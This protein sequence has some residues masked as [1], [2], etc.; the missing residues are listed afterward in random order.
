MSKML[1]VL[2]LTLIISV[3]SSGQI[4]E[5]LDD[6]PYN[7]QTLNQPIY[8]V[9]VFSLKSNFLN[10]SIFFNNATFDVDKFG[11]DSQQFPGWPMITD[12]VFF[13]DLPIVVDIDHDGEDEVVSLGYRIDRHNDIPRNYI[14]LID[15]DGSIMPGFPIRITDA[16]SLNVAD[17]DGD[18]EY[19]IMTYSVSEKRLRCFDRFGYT[20]PGWPIEIPNDLIGHAPFGSGGAVGDL[21]MDGTNEYIL[22]GLFHIYA[23][24]FDGSMQPGFPIAIFDRTFGFSN[25]W[26]WPPVLVDIDLDGFLEIVTTA[27]NWIDNYPPQLISFVAIYEHDSSMKT[28]WPVYFYDDILQHAPTPGD[29]DND[30]TIEIGIQGMQLNFLDINGNQLPGWPITLYKPGGGTWGCRS[31]LIIVDIDGDGDC[32]IFTDYST[33]YW[34]TTTWNGYSYFFGFNHSGN[35]L[36]G[37]PFLVEGVYHVRPPSFGYDQNTQ[38]LYMGLF[39]EFVWPPQGIDSAYIEIYQFPD[40]TGP[41]DQWPKVSHDNLM[42]RNYNFVDNVTGIKSGAD[43]LPKNHVLKQNYPN[44]FNSSTTIEFALPE[45]GVVSL[46]IYDILGRE[47]KR[48]VSGY[49]ESGNHTVAVDIDDA[50]SGVYFYILTTEKSEISRSMVLIK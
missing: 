33:L 37:Y 41:T 45:D 38:R 13:V 32:E 2:L 27:D 4:P 22:M 17:L 23:Y 5:M 18:G 36:S 24:R 16:S 43:V 11:F 39:T 47:V 21:D 20:K 19:E 14:Y 3:P 25:N 34:D 10:S 30:G 40:S 44:P 6:W 35:L 28:G 49:R 12:P 9:P 29:I 48:P 1:L 42:T 31:D 46:A 26:T 7:T 50:G 15:D 8:P